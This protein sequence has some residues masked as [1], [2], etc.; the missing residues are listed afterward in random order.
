MRYL[1][2]LNERIT[3]VRC[4]VGTTRVL[5][6]AELSHARRHELL[7][8]PLGERFVEREMQRTLRLLIVREVLSEGWKH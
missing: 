2:T 6:D 5:A 3:A 4:E 7:H 8:E 1:R